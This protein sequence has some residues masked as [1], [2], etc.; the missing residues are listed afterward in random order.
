MQNFCIYITAKL[1]EDHENFV[2][3][4]VLCGNP[5]KCCKLITE[6][7][8]VKELYC[9][10]RYSK[11]FF[12]MVYKKVTHYKVWSLVKHNLSGFRADLKKTIAGDFLT[13]LQVLFPSFRTDSPEKIFCS[14]RQIYLAGKNWF[15][16]TCCC[17]S[18]IF[19]N[20]P[21]LK[22]DFLCGLLLLLWA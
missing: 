4:C 12:S 2:P 18:S 10:Y 22:D 6:C 1:E 20:S 17:I 11:F 3:F 14:N 19:K 7:S 8:C 13:R 16:L 15:F 21:I 5:Q 9:I